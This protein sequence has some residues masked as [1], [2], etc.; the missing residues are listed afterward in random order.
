MTRE[1]FK[2]LKEVRT[3]EAR[4]DYELEPIINRRERVEA[5]QVF[6]SECMEMYGRKDR[7]GYKLFPGRL[8]DFEPAVTDFHGLCELFFER[9][10]MEV[11]K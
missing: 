8:S 4:H 11:A 1:Q 2:E 3:Y 5:I 6:S 7:Y 9:A 10:G